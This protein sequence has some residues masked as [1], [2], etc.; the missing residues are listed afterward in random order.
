M[1]RPFSGQPNRKEHGARFL[2]N[3]L[4]YFNKH[5]VSNRTRAIVKRVIRLPAEKREILADDIHTAFET[6]LDVLE[7]SPSNMPSGA[8]RK[9]K[10]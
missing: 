8:V 9:V 4:S 1:A 10:E 2:P 7:R 3:W 6:R 5:N